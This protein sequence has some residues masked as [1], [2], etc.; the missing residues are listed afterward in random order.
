MFFI[1]SERTE[2][3]AKPQNRTVIVGTSVDL[4]CKATADPLLELRYIWKRDGADVTDESNIQWLE[5]GN[6]LKLA[7][8]RFEEAGVYTCVAYTPE[9]RGSEDSASAIVSVTGTTRILKLIEERS[10]PKFS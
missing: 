5:D 4:R 10:Q 6:V 9:P 7:N 1:T 2:I 8:I 3:I